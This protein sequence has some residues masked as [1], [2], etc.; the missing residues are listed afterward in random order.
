M[1]VDC[2]LR[3]TNFPVGKLFTIAFYTELLGP[4]PDLPNVLLVGKYL[5]DGKP[6][7]NEAS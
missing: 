6:A 5:D 1:V 2:R 3:N 7:G 4:F